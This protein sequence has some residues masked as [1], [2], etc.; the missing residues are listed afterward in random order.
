MTHRP[1]GSFTG[2]MRHITES[3]RLKIAV[4]APIPR[5]IESTAIAVKPG[6]LDSVRAANR[7]SWAQLPK[8]PERLIL[9]RRRAPLMVSRNARSKARGGGEASLPYLS[10]L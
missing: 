3:I 8:R 1:A 7:K 6:A 9:Q 10:G 2:S 5:A 4:F